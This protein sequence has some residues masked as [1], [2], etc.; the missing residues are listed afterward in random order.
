MFPVWSGPANLVLR[1]FEVAV[2]P[3]RHSDEEV[4]V[5]VVD[6]SM[7]LAPSAAARRLSLSKQRLVQLV[8][9]GKLAAI[10]TPNGRLFDVAVVEKFARERET[11]SEGAGQ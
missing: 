5:T 9:E 2:A 1:V 8:N 3:V 4:S 6:L 11:A 7:T 10:A